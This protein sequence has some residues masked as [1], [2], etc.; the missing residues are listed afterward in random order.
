MTLQDGA[1]THREMEP[2]CRLHQ[3]ATPSSA[4]RAPAQGFIIQ[5]N[6]SP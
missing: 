2:I 3:P 4:R 6:G 5:T 1:P